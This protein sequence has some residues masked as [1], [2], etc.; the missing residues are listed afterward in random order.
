MSF[1]FCC[2]EY[3]KTHKQITL[4]SHAHAQKTTFRTGMNLRT[5]LSQLSAEEVHNIQVVVQTDRLKIISFAYWVPKKATGV[6]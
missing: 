3:T 2:R 1:S 5:G 4:Y 6:H